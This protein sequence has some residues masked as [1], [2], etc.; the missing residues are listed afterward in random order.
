MVFGLLILL[1]Q[2][3]VLP[4]YPLRYHFRGTWSIPYWQLKQ[5][6][7]VQMDLVRG[8]SVED[9]FNGY[10]IAVHERGKVK[11]SRQVYAKDGA[12]M[13]YCVF[14][15]IRNPNDELVKYIPD[16][17]AQWAYAGEKVVLGRLCDV[18]ESKEAQPND[19]WFYRFY[20]D[21]ATGEPVRYHQR[22]KSIRGS[23]PTDYLLDFEEF[24]PSIDEFQ[25]LIPAD[26]RNASQPNGPQLA[27]DIHLQKGRA[28]GARDYAFTPLAQDKCANVSS[29]AGV[30][31]L[32]AEFSWR[33]YANVVPKVRDQ[34]NC[35]S[36]WAQSA[37]EAISAQF[38]MALGKQVTVSA[39]QMVDCTWDEERVN[40]ACDG[41]EGYAGFHVLAAKGMA[42]TT[43]EEYPYIGVGG[44]CPSAPF[45]KV[46]GNVTGCMQF[47]PEQ[48][49]AKHE[50]LKKALY[51]YGPL[52]VSIR[53]GIDSF[54][55]L[56]KEN[57]YHDDAELCNVNS[58][59]S[60]NVDH[61]VLLTGW[62]VHNGKSYFEI[63]NSWSTFWGDDGFG[64]ISEENDCGIESMVLLPV[65]RV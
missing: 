63:M 50:L 25:F 6:F 18:W 48:H 11:A 29:V 41:G 19:S 38:G 14:S 20:A 34:A 52:M 53:A 16:D 22:G 24:G 39:Q 56:S 58:W 51:K 61:G 23:H 15:D 30:G 65:V 4:K 8:R 2:S 13:E 54:V 33:N 57:P 40:N 64:Y 59:E 27:K 31:A 45:E 62:K 46:L 32:P 36:C 26:C 17:D 7:S 10:M 28:D 3:K 42:I 5:P 35:G 1:V 60:N 37:T 49:D 55:S 47:V 12:K 9:T 44:Y 43:E 21:A